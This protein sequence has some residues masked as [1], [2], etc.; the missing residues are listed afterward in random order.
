MSNQTDFIE[1]AAELIRQTLKI[2][3][4]HEDNQQPP[5]PTE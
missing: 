4:D 5:K 2:F 3:F 1:A